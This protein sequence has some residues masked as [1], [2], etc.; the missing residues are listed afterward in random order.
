[1]KIKRT[2]RRTVSPTELQLVAFPMKNLLLSFLRST[3]PQIL[4]NIPIHK[5][6]TSKSPK[7]VLHYL[8]L[9]RNRNF[10]LKFAKKYRKIH[11]KKMQNRKTL[12]IFML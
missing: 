1:M 2:E 9:K 8:V 10:Y 3:Y 6:K 4:S 5:H 7:F 12:H 11:N